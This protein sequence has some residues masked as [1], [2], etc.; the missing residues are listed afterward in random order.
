MR[1]TGWPLRG[2]TE[3]RGPGMTDWE[4]GR[5]GDKVTGNAWICYDGA[6]RV[7]IFNFQCENTT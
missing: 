4:T 5:F 6:L 3:D 2:Q 7:L 1:K